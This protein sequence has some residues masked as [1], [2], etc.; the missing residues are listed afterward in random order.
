[1]AGVL[2]NLGTPTRI[3]I[4]RSQPNSRAKGALN[5]RAVAV[6]TAG[7]GSADLGAKGGVLAMAARSRRLLAHI[8]GRQ[9]ESTGED[10]EDRE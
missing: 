7:G 6:A 5:I 10:E 4:S 9:G 1:M 3:E 2:G 8:P